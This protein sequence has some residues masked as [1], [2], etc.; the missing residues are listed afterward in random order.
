[1]ITGGITKKQDRIEGEF[2]VSG[3]RGGRTRVWG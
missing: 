1:M 2:A 3:R